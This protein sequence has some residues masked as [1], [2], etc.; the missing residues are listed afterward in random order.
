M[1]ANKAFVVKKVGVIT[2]NIAGAEASA[3]NVTGQITWSKHDS[4]AR[5][6]EVAKHR[7]NFI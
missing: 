1:L 7:A 5:A 3:Q 6:W 4:P 2:G